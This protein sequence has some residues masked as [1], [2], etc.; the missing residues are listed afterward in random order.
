MIVVECKL[1]AL[2]FFSSRSCAALFIHGMMDA[3]AERAEDMTLL[4]VGVDAIL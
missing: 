3:E 4:L 1:A 2:F